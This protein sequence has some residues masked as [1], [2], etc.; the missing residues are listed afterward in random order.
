MNNVVITPS[1]NFKDIAE[2]VKAL[3]AELDPCAKENIENT[4]LERVAK[5]LIDSSKI[6]AFIAKH[7]N[8]NIGIITLHECA[9]IYAGGVFGEISELYVKPAHRSSN[10]GALLLNAAIEKANELEWKRLEVGSPPPNKS[11]RTIKFYES[12]G[13]KS[14]GTRLRRLI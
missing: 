12:K 11:P 13:F 10:I 3:L 4:E 5:D 7:N 1:V 8:E 14:T 6:W 2:L 9:A